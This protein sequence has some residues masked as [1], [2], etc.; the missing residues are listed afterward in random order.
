MRMT[1]IVCKWALIAMIPA[2]VSYAHAQTSSPT[3]ATTEAFGG[4][5]ARARA[6]LERDNGHLWGARLDSVAWLGVDGKTILLS[7]KP[8]DAG[9][10]EL[11]GL[12]EGP[13]PATV[14]PSNSS[15]A[16]GGRTWAMILLPTPPGDSLM[17]ERLFIHEAM[18][19]LQP[20]VLPAPAY[21]ETGTGSAALDEPVGR[22]WLRLELKALSTAL[23]ASGGS[24]DDAVRDALLFRAERYA[25]MSADEINRERA[26]DV[27][28]GI[29]EYTGWKLSESPRAE[30]EASID[31]APAQ[32]PSLIRAFV[33][34]TGP[35][36]AMLLDD[37]T[38][39]T[40]RKSLGTKLD[41]QSMTAGAIASHHVADMQV[42]DAGLLA[43]LS[44]M[45]KTELASLA[46]AQSRLYGSAE[47]VADE[48]VRWAKRQ[49]QL[50]QFRAK[51]L[52][53]PGVMIRPHSLNISFDP[54]GQASLGSA[55]TVMA[56]L[57]WK[58]ADGTS[59]TAPDGALV[60]STWTELRVPL[61]TARLQPGIVTSPM[62]IHGTG[63]TLTL[64]PG[65]SIAAE[66]GSMVLTPPPAQH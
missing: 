65:W 35:A 11:D 47:I 57:A 14:T 54:R 6:A 37:Y 33:Y 41:L 53:E 16:W 12:W 40:W 50:A 44:A 48:N 23:R 19:V 31:S 17:I 3:V 46:T 55:G 13:L 22:S 52:N 43:T 8:T 30:F 61:G 10:T 1:A 38:D 32:F 56:N 7:A 15:V 21:S 36:Y 28:E 34:F 29:P 5:V 58:S 64:E 26:L 66:K 4:D 39:G 60:N 2:A 63:W 45:Q 25:N 42:I 51:F 27:K 49:K 24:R 20:S 62:T 9:Y 18:H 59:L